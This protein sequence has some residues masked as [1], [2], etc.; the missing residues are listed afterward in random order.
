MIFLSDLHSKF[1][2]FFSILLIFILFALAY[3]L[4]VEVNR[5]MLEGKTLK[6]NFFR[7]WMLGFMIWLGPI[8]AFLSGPHIR[9]SA[10][11]DWEVIVYALGFGIFFGP[12]LA[13]Q[14]GKEELIRQEY[15]NSIWIS[16][17]GGILFVYGAFWL[18]H[19]SILLSDAI[20]WN[21]AFVF[22]AITNR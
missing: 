18:S 7:L 19:L 12:M 13:S 8:L 16:M 4:L 15:T 3:P 2:N 10:M 5:R 21:L 6:D 14:H 1:Q 9:R 17:I 20:L 11:L 22:E